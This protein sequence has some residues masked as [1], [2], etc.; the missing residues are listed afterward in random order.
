MDR[1]EGVQGPTHRGRNRYANIALAFGTPRIGT[2]REFGANRESLSNDSSTNFVDFSTRPRF[3]TC[4][5]LMVFNYYS[6]RRS[7]AVFGL[8]VLYNH[9]DTLS[10]LQTCIAFRKR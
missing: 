2:L 1:L 10:D 6:L 4:I 9:T 8:R 5:P 7:H 3:D